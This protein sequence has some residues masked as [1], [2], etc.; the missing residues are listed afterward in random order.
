MQVQDALLNCVVDLYR[1]ANYI[2]P[3]LLCSFE[4]ILNL[5]EDPLQFFKV[6]GPNS[7]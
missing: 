3:F 6:G 4:F 1:A 7:L 2:L 5:N